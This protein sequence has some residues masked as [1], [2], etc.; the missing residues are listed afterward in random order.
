MNPFSRRDVKRAAWKAAWDSAK[1]GDENRVSGT[2][3]WLIAGVIIL[4]VL[5]VIFGR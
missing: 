4:A 2:V 3:G 1:K 5:I